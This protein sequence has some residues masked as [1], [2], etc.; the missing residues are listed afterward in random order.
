MK[1][2]F[3]FNKILALTKSVQR[4]ASKEPI[5]MY[6][7]LLSAKKVDFVNILDPLKNILKFCLQMICFMSVIFI[8]FYSLF[9]NINEIMHT[10]YLHHSETGDTIKLLKC[11]TD[12]ALYIE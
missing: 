2:N 4:F 9:I 5:Q 8:I 1:N 12:S 7:E 11:Y 3:I 6:W 10:A